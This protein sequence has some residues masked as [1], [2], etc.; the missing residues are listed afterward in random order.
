MP[1]APAISHAFF[2][3]FLSNVFHIFAFLL[4]PVLSYVFIVV[5]ASYVLA[6]KSIGFRHFVETILVIST[7][8]KNYKFMIVQQFVL[9]STYFWTSFEHEKVN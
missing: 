4:H 7:L 3:L 2:S 8:L 6:F 1:L 5:K 9:E